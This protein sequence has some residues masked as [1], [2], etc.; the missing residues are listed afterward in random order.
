MILSDKRKSKRL[1]RPL[2]VQFRQLNGVSSYSLGMTLNISSDGLC[3]QF[4]NIALAIGENLEFRLKKPETNLSAIVQGNV[5]WIQN[6]GTKFTAGIKFQMTSKKNRKEMQRII[7]DFF[8][9]PPH[10]LSN[11]QGRKR[12]TKHKRCINNGLESDNVQTNGSGSGREIVKRGMKIC[13]NLAIITLITVAFVLLIPVITAHHEDA[14]KN[15]FAPFVQ[16]ASYDNSNSNL[17]MLVSKIR[18]QNENINSHF[19]SETESIAEENKEEEFMEEAITLP[20][21]ENNVDIIKPLTNN[22]RSGKFNFYVQVTSLRDPDIAYDML[23]KIKNYYPE[24]YFFKINN[25]YKIRI[26]GINSD[27][28]GAEIIKV[29]EEKLDIESTLVYRLK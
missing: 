24:A 16:T 8:T 23:L 25:V 5:R 27:K 12:S 3:F 26:P 28:Q 13:L 17:S 14:P 18:T 11:K 1:G 15:T 22:E 21:Q 4:Q 7:S 9:I 19:N 29:L 10:L 20:E 2:F 6:Q